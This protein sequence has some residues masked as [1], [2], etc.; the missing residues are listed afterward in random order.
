VG[1]PQIYDFIIQAAAIPEPSHF[2]ALA[3]MGLIG[4][5]Y[6]HYSRRMLPRNPEA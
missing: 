2:L 3:A 6:T 1:H 4:A 5:A